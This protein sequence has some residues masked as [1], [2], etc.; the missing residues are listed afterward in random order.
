LGGVYT[1]VALLSAL[2]MGTQHVILL[3]RDPARLPPA[4]FTLNGMVG[5]G[6]GLATWLSFTR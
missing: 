1:G 2:I 3:A 6:L 5:L 4:F